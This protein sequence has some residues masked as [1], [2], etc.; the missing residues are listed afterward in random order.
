MYERDTILVLKEQRDA[1]P[2]TGE[3]F[4]YNRVRVVGESPVAHTH[5]GEWEGADARGVIIQPVTNFGSNLDEP[6]GKL[7]ELY[8]VESIPEVVVPVQQTVKIVNAT[9]AQAG[10]TPEEVFAAEAPGT[11]PEEGQIRGR[12]SPL[13]GPGGPAAKDGPLGKTPSQRKKA[14]S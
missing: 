7:R 2:E 13:G 11:P 3:A 14:E 8:S 5:K 6:F 1:D 9:T 4:A 10:P 12:T